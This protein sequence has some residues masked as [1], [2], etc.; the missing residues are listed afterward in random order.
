MSKR[1][2]YWF[3]VG[4]FIG[5]AIGFYETWLIWSVFK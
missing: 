1:C 3:I 2:K 4:L 5:V